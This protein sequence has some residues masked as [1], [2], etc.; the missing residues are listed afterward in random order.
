MSPITFVF[1]SM[2]R[3]TSENPLWYTNLM[4]LSIAVPCYN[5]EEALPYFKKRFNEIASQMD[6]ISFELILINDG[7]RD[8]T[9]ALAN[10]LADQDPRVQVLSLSRNWGKEAALHAGLS[11]ST[12]D[13]VAVMDADLQDPPELLMEMLR[14]LRET[15]CDCVATKRVTRTGEPPARSF[16]AR[17]FYRWINRVSPIHVED[18]ARDFRLMRREMVD[19]VLSLTERRRF[20]KGLFAWVGFDV[21]YIGYENVERVAGVTKWSFWSLFRYAIEGIISL[22]PAP[23]YFSFILS[24]VCAFTCICLLCFAQWAPALMTGITALILLG[25]GTLGRYIARIFDEVKKR[26]LFIR[27]GSYGIS[28]GE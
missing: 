18:G 24:A 14:M 7:S 9:L 22:T 21:R 13:F 27:K 28:Q 20:S 26:P 4:R 19:A 17:A 25:I 12:G 16:F 5:E 1:H 11:F 6:G 15:G 10:A 23:L 3:F 2:A 8:G